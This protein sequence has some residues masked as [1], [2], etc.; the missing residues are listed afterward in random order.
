MTKQPQ[1]PFLTR[2]AA[3]QLLLV[4]FCTSILGFGLG[5]LFLLIVP[6]ARVHAIDI[7]AWLWLGLSILTLLLLRTVA[8][9]N[10]VTFHQIGFAKPNI[11]FLHLLWQIPSLIIIALI[12]QAIVASL[13]GLEPPKDRGVDI[14]HQ[15]SFAAGIAAAIAVSLLVP[16]WEEI[17]FRGVLYGVVRARLGASLA[18]IIT[19]ILFA[20]AHINPILTPYL[21]VMGLGLGFIRAFH[22]N[23]WASVIAH[24]TLNSLV[25]LL[26][27]LAL[28]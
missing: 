12:V 19:G 2:R 14:V 23:V 15:A 13:I 11:K 24:A 20:A 25:T 18:V 7:F 10:G 17:T 4:P 8:R 6:A 3:I 27:F 26:V 28:I 1:Q 9:R 22:Q 16:L 5:F 21:L